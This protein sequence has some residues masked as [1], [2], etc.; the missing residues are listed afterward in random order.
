MYD[1][2]FNMEGFGTAPALPYGV[3][4][5][6]RS[7]TNAPIAF[8]GG[9][10]VADPYPV[11]ITPDIAIGRGSATSTYG[12]VVGFR[13]R[14]DPKQTLY[15]YDTK[16]KQIILP[17]GHRI[18]SGDAYVALLAQYQ[19]QQ[20]SSAA[21]ANYAQTVQTALSNLAAGV[22]AIPSAYAS[23]RTFDTEAA[24][25]AQQQAAL[26]TT[27]AQPATTQTSGGM[28]TWLWFVILGGGAFVVW[29]L[30]SGKKE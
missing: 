1:N 7:D 22:S 25:L 6:D 30:M 26:T 15:Y 4:G 23:S 21:Q 9:V 28:P 20:G 5:M 17:N 16:T 10:T 3:H 24:R 19:A 8:K 14:S 29:S 18:S 13:D 2:D 11:Q 27:T 12:D